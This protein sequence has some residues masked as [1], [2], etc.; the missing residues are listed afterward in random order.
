MTI[1]F[2]HQ[3]STGLN[4][5]CKPVKIIRKREGIRN[6]KEENEKQII[7]DEQYQSSMGAAGVTK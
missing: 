7:K 1:V 2:Q 6:S 3:K 4:A 5:W